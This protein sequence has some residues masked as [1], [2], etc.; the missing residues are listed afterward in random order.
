MNFERWE[1]NS[2]D[3]RLIRTMTD[4]NSNDERLIR[5]MSSYF[6][7]REKHDLADLKQLNQTFWIS[8]VFKCFLMISNIF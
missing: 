5:T 4:F 2:N 3:E 1:P 7:R 8:D 6:E